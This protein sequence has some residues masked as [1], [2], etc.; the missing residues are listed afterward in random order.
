MFVKQNQ[1]QKIEN[2]V[3]KLMKFFERFFD[4]SSKEI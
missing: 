3:E 2:V 4:I 1:R